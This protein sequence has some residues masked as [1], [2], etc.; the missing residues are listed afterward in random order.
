MRQPHFVFIVTYLTVKRTQPSLLCSRM[1]TATSILCPVCREPVDRLLYRY[2]IDGEKRVIEQI[3]QQNPGWAEHDGACSRCVDYYH[4][5]VVMQQRMLPEIGPYFPVKSQDDFIILPTGLRLNTDQRFTGKGVTICFIDSSFCR[6][7]DLTAHRN[8]IKTIIDVTKMTDAINGYPVA[9]CHSELTDCHPEL[10]EGWH[11][12]MTSVVCAGDGYLSNGLY[13]G[14]ASDVEL[15]LIKVQNA[16]G[17]ITTESIVKALQWVLR[18]HKEYGIRIVNMS[19]GD[20][21]AISYKQSEV[22]QYAEQ[23]VQKGITVVAAAGNDMD[24]LINPPAN[25]PH[26]IT[27]G[28]IDDNN[29]LQKENGLYHSAWGKTTDGLMKPELIAHAIWIAAPIL[30]GTKEQNEAEVLHCLLSVS[31]DVLPVVLKENIALTGLPMSVLASEDSTFIKETILQRIRYCKYIS[32]HYMHVDGTSFAAP[33]VSAVIAQLLEADPR[34]T[35]AMIRKILFTT[36]K[37]IENYPAERQG[38]GAIHPRKAILHVLK[39]E[40]IMA[41]EESPRINSG[42]NTIAFYVQHDCASQ[43]SLAGSFN[44]WAKDVLL[45][46][47]GKYGWWKIEVPM[48]APGKYYYKFFVDEKIWVED[49]S[50]PYREPDGFNGFNSVLTI[51]N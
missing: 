29:D 50:N 19:I 17:R 36:A 31:P 43:V 6:H 35:P 46:E 7:P 22:D 49:V 39:K 21:E 25:S 13:K 48:M 37:R 18:H 4:T 47:P 24:G 15:V 26:V 10:A 23:L 2:H 28:G 20:D 41:P 45:L 27:V 9:G 16:A 3:K 40:T 44:E 14:I 12:T 30:P 5:E 1:N 34:L 8:R 33:I 51:N 42:Q 32:P 11:G 38:F